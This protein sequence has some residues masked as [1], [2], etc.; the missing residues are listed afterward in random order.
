MST[1][2]CPY[3]QCEIQR[4]AEICP[5]CA[6][7]ARYPNV[8]NAEENGEK[9]ALEGRYL[10]AAAALRSV[11]ASNTLDAFEAALRDSRAVIARPLCEVARLA[12]AD[13]Q[14][15]A[16]FYQI[17]QSGTQV[18]VDN[19]WDRRR[20]IA[21][22]TLFQNFQEKIRFG[23]L[24]LDGNGLPHY[25]EC[26]LVLSN[27]FI[28]HRTSLLEEN[29]V[30]FINRHGIDPTQPTVQLPSG[31][32]STWDDR[33]KLCIAKLALALGATTRPNDFAAI[34][35]RPGATSADDQFV[36][37]HTWGSITRRSLE[38]VVIRKGVTRSE[39]K[40]QKNVILKGLQ[41]K[42]KDANVAVQ[43]GT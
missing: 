35:M 36:E 5:H 18:A 17:T 25:G 41:E 34:L 26:Y 3:C 10:S 7:P 1:D 23:C 33:H 43:I 6:R 14:I 39:R 22:I 37:A 15:Y 40:R 29:S 20:R 13:N 42:L 24:S 28:A 32:R 19:D 11:G 2:I 21:D 9:V 4:S 12:H 16:T 27:K 30:L 31:Y 8:L 38:C